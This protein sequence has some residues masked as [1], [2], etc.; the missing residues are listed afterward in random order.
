MAPMSCERA[1]LGVTALGGQLY[2][3]GG[4]SDNQA[5]TSVERYDPADNRWSSVTSMTCKRRCLGVAVLEDH[6]Y[7]VGGQKNKTPPMLC[8]H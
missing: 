8:S 6:L 2:A 1:N 4:Q 7:A 5:V 3:V